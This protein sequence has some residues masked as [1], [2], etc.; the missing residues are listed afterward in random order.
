MG[1]VRQ[2]LMA[3]VIGIAM[4]I[5]LYYGPVVIDNIFAGAVA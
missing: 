4:A 2:S 5:A 3:A 1:V